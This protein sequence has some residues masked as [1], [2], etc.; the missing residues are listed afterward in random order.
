MK[1]WVLIVVSMT[2]F[3]VVQASEIRVWEKN[4]G[5]KIEAQF[6]DEMFGKM[7]LRKSDGKEVA[8]PV[9]ALSEHDQKYLRV[10]VPPKVSI[11]FEKHEWPY[12]K[13]PELWATSDIVEWIKGTVTIRKMSKRVFTSRL[14]AELF[15]IAKEV[16]GNHHILLQKTDTSFLLGDHNDNQHV[17]SSEP[18]TVRK[19]DEQGPSSW[20]G[21]IYDGYLIVVSDKNGTILTTKTD[22]PGQWI[23]TPE[24]IA[25]LRELWIKGSASIRSRHFDE[26][27]KKAA[28]TRPLPYGFGEVS[29]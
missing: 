15:L 27:G 20:R 10:M 3:S 11:D 1:I 12:K 13:P 26:K 2:F 18:V 17:F 25:N 6:V 19:Y 4:N 5:E 29:K 21:E 8:V 24:M 28:V 14:Y 23:Q 16:D 7:I 22:Y 9:E